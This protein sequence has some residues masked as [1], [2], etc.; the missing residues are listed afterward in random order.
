MRRASLGGQKKYP[1][2]EP[3][4][5]SGYEGMVQWIATVPADSLSR[6]GQAGQRIVEL[7]ENWGKSDKAAEWRQKVHAKSDRPTKT[8]GEN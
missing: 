6:V 8:S 7:C 2:A 1:D 5:I 3:L 4:L